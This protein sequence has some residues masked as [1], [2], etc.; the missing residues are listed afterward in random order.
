MNKKKRL[1]VIHPALAPYR[2]DFFN[3]LNYNFESTFYFFNDN[4]LNQKFNQDNLKQS[5]DFKCN[6]IK[7]GFN[8]FGRSLRFGITA[9]IRQE[10]PDIILLPE[11]N[12]LNIT[13]IL[14]RFLFNKKF[15]IYSICDDNIVVASNATLL[16]KVLRSFQLK[17]VNGV[18][19]TH[20]GILEW[21]KKQLNPNS[22][23]LIFPIIR[24]EKNFKFF[25]E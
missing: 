4:L 23:L 9:I 22:D 10:K 14:Y 16:R 6:Y 2:V 18:I 20:Y 5:I 15:K 21:Y 8:F 17:Y 13:V 12:V 11:Y 24:E 25:I 1:L 19:L 3:S 7:N